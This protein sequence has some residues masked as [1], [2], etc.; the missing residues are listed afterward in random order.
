[1]LKFII[2]VTQYERPFS[3]KGLSFGHKLVRLHVT[4]LVR[5]DMT[6]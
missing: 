3:L 5:K 4:H 1:M 6:D 2:N